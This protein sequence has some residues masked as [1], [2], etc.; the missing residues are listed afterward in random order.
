MI[1][2]A[3][4]K[5]LCGFRGVPLQNQGLASDLLGSWASLSWESQDGLSWVSAW[6]LE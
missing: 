2:K 4:Q 1:P 5:P 3:G 6:A